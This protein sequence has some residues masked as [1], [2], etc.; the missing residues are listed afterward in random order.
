MFICT[1]SFTRGSNLSTK[2][3]NVRWRWSL[4]AL[5]FRGPERGPEERRMM[6]RMIVM[7][8]M[9]TTAGLGIFPA[10]GLAG[11]GGGRGLG[12]QGGWL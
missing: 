1:S 5:I 7:M 4:R 9:N 11:G 8:R 12:L 2:G 3:S 10:V 6:R